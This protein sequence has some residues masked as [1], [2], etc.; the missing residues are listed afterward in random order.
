MI[1][2]MPVLLTDFCEVCVH[3]LLGAPVAVGR[4]HKV[5][6]ESNVAYREDD[7][8]ENMKPKSKAFQPL[9]VFLQ[10]RENDRGRSEHVFEGRG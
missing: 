8:K 9:G 1:S 10:H 4:E 3:F 2:S 5:I 6:K 7:I